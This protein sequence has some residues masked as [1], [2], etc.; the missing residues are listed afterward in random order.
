M[1]K[2]PAKHTVTFT[3]DNLAYALAQLTRANEGT[4]TVLPLL[5][6]AIMA[7]VV[8]PALTTYSFELDG[9]SYEATLTSYQWGAISAAINKGG[10]VLASVIGLLS[11]L[12]KKI[13]GGVC[14]LVDT[15]NGA[16]PTSKTVAGSQSPVGCCTFDGQQK[17]LT[18][19]QCSQYTMSSWNGGDPNCTGKPDGGGK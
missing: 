2:P 11:D 1:A 14:G 19:L 6:N 17:P 12:T 18:Q 16:S 13:S 15:L 7:P 9:G 10:D 8:V 3:H 4:A 5:W